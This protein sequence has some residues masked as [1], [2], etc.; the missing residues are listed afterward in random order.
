MK[1]ERRWLAPV[2]GRHTKAEIRSADRDFSAGDEL[3]LHTPDTSNDEIPGY[4]GEA[5]L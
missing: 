5:S 3:L 4:V 1:I 2:T